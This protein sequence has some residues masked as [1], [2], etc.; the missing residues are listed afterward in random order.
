MVNVHLTMCMLG[1]A[2]V[3]S[4]GCQMPESCLWQTC[5]VGS[6]SCW[7]TL[8]CDASGNDCYLMHTSQIHE[9][10]NDHDED[11]QIGCTPCFNMECPDCLASW[12]GCQPTFD[13][14]HVGQCPNDPELGKTCGKATHSCQIIYLSRKDLLPYAP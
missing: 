13:S 2:E 8:D 7:W 1:L 14:M 3:V 10:A 5:Q 6:Y 11:C 4:R 9:C 12:E